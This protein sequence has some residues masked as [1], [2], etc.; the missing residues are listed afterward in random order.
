MR[1]RVVRI[2]PFGATAVTSTSARLSTAPFWL[3]GHQL[4]RRLLQQVQQRLINLQTALDFLKHQRNR[5][6]GVEFPRY[7]GLTTGRLL[8][9]QRWKGELGV[10]A[11]HVELL[12]AKVQEASADGTDEEG[13]GQ[14]VFAGE[15]S[16]GN[17]LE[18][19]PRSSSEQVVI[20]LQLQQSTVR[21]GD[22]V[23]L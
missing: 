17:L 11:V 20:A 4:G 22:K 5:I 8:R 10:N 15:V 23:L 9:E 3:L 21:Q 13:L 18:H 1:P 7:L 19:V 16:F 14:L 2:V 12:G 6:V